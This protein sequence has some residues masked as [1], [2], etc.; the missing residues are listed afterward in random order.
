MPKYRLEQKMKVLEALKADQ[1]YDSLSEK[2]QIPVSTIKR[3]Y[4]Q[5]EAIRRDYHL[6]LRDEAHHK[7]VLVQHRM[8]DKAV[9][10]IAA[11]DSDR[12]KNAPLNQVASALGLVIDR[13]L[14]L[15][16]A[17]EESDATHTEQVIRYEFRHPDGTIRET[18]YF[19][20][21]RSR[22]TGTVQSGSVWETLGQDGIGENYINGK[23]R[24]S[25][26]ED[27]VAGSDVSDGES[28]MARFEDDDDERDWYHD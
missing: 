20:E 26:S 22:H 14:K 28:G 27:M 10:L 6:H 9:E 2:E 5:R 21:G 7:M 17:Q 23:S 4:Q 8:A 24:L 13:F 3:W 12:I 11:L 15:Q 25:G 19:A 1:N 18:P 16:D